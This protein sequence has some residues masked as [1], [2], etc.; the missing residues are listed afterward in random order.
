MSHSLLD[1]P[2]RNERK[3]EF[4]MTVKLPSL[5]DFLGEWEIIKLIQDNKGQSSGNFSG[6]A[7]FK[8]QDDRTA[9][10]HEIGTLKLNSGQSLMAERRYRWLQESNGQVAV[11][12]EGG[13]PFHLVDLNESRPSGHHFCDPDSYQVEYDFSD[14]PN[15]KSIW[16]VTGPRKDYV[17]HSEFRRKSD[18]MRA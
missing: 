13:R 18:T 10:Y 1:R 14:W 15:W 4:A 17:M 12:F 16:R 8:N 3:F 2:Q 11:Q 5:Q 7:Q 6:L 9:L